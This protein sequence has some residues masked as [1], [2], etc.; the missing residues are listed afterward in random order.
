MVARYLGDG[1]NEPSSSAETVLTVTP[2]PVAGATSTNLVVTNRPV[3]RGE[4][5]ALDVT[6]TGALGT[7]T[8]SVTVVDKATDS[9]LATSDLSGGKATLSFTTSTPGLLT[10]QATYSGD[11]TY[12]GSRSVFRRLTVQKA[13]ADVSLKLSDSSGHPKQK[14]TAT[15]KVATV[16]GIPATGRVRLTDNG[17]IVGKG[18]ATNGKVK[19]S[20]KP[21]QSGKHRLRAV[22]DGDATY[23]P[24]TSSKR[25]YTVD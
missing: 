16:N 10:L 13:H 12:A 8:G 4:S 24:G 19:V 11:A 3:T 2:K 5:V 14:V 17:L 18:T 1:S 22:Y 23:R 15:I 7:P 20:Y 9:V 25:V 6:V 21:K